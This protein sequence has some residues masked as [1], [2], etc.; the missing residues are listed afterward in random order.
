MIIKYAINICDANEWRPHRKRPLKPSDV[1]KS[2]KKKKQLKAIKI[3]LIIQQDERQYQ[4]EE[5]GEYV[6]GG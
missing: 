4:T 6:G 3:H 2:A 5:Q 1:R